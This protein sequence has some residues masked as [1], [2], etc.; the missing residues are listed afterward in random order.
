MP[1]GEDPWGEFE[2]EEEKDEYFRNLFMQAE[3]LPTGI[4]AAQGVMERLINAGVRSLRPGAQAGGLWHKLMQWNLNPGAG[5]SAISTKLL[6][7]AAMLLGLAG[8]PRTPYGHQYGVMYAD[9]F[10]APSPYL[11]GG[12]PNTPEELERHQQ[13]MDALNPPTPPM[14]TLEFNQPTTTLPGFSL[15]TQQQQITSALIPPPPVTRK[16][17]STRQGQKWRRPAPTTRGGAR[18]I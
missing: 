7:S 2:T 14:P 13:V 17:K 16:P 3:G 9:M 18:A 1:N 4:F 11:V 8:E 5:V 10:G 15:P 6:P 12:D